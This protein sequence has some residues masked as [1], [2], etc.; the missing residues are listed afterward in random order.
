MKNKFLKTIGCLAAALAL[1]ACND[2]ETADGNRLPEGKYPVTF[3]ATGLQMPAATRSTTDGTWGLTAAVVAVKIGY[4]VKRY[5][6][7]MTGTASTTLKPA[8]G[9]IPFYW[10]ST[11]DI[12][13]SAWYLGT[14]EYKSALPTHW[15]V[16]TNQNNYDNGYQR[17]DFLYAPEADIDFKGTKLLTFYHQTAKVVVNIRNQGVVNNDDEN[18]KSVTINAVT[19]GTFQADAGGNYRLSAKTGTGVTSTDIIF[20]KLSSPNA[21]VVFKDGE[22]GEPALASYQALVIPQ[23]LNAN[24]SIKIQI[25]GYNTFTYTPTGSWEGGTQYTYNLTIDGKGVKVNAISTIGWTDG[26]TGEGSVEI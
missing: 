3:I 17:S 23:T 18:I 24:T 7:D 16:Q 13:V 26:G 4:E 12:K 1:T 20:K 5:V 21:D 22:K 19:D 14:G 6:A 2:D 15:S 8:E 25:E 11:A 10:Q 9:I